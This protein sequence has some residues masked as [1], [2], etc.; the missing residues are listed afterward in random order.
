MTTALFASPCP[1]EAEKIK[2]INKDN[3]GSSLDPFVVSFITEKHNYTDSC[4]R[5]HE[6]THTSLRTHDHM[7]PATSYKDLHTHTISRT[8]VGNTRKQ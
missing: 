2:E 1:D 7:H 8:H 4:R 5:T 3:R 6:S